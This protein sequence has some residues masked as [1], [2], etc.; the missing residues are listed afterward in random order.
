MRKKEGKKI[1]PSQQVTNNN[2]KKER[3]SN[4]EEEINR[5]GNEGRIYRDAMRETPPSVA[6][7]WQQGNGQGAQ[8]RCIEIYCCQINWHIFQRHLSG[9]EMKQDGLREILIL[10]LVGRSGIQKNES[11]ELDLDQITLPV[12][13][14]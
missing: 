3:R 1:T 6:A 11:L 7:S 4:L 2:G 14:K 8:K 10:N 12:V 9:N 13:K 5:E